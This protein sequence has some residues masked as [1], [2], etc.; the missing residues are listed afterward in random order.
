M[1]NQQIFYCPSFNEESTKQATSD[2]LCDGPSFLSAWPAQYY[3]SH[4][5]MSS[6]VMYGSCTQSD[7][8]FA[9]AGSEG[10][11]SL[12]RTGRIMS[13][14]EVV[15]PSET[16]HICEGATMIGSDGGIWIMF[17]SEGAKRH[18]EGS[19]LGFLDGHAK[20]IKGDPQ[21]ELMTTG[22]CVHA[23]YFDYRR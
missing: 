5:G 1:K 3:Y 9:W 16:A 13:L 21:L 6:Y 17:G 19:V 11:L 2:P 18:Q 7:P 4:Y 23:R 14:S 15:R 12:T 10:W 22:N 20:W 8:E